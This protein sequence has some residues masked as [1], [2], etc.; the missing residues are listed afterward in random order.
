MGNLEVYN[1]KELANDSER[2]KREYYRNEVYKLGINFDLLS[3]E[4]QK[5]I[6]DFFI[7]LKEDELEKTEKSEKQLITLIKKGDKKT[8]DKMFEKLSDCEFLSLENENG[9][10]QIYLLYEINKNISC[11]FEKLMMV[12]GNFDILEQFSIVRN[13][14]FKTLRDILNEKVEKIQCFGMIEE[15]IISNLIWSWENIYFFSNRTKIERKIYYSMFEVI[16]TELKERVAKQ[17]LEKKELLITSNYDEI[18]L[19]FLLLKEL[20]IGKFGD[21]EISINCNQNIEQLKEAFKKLFGEAISSIKFK[22]L[23]T[24]NLRKDNNFSKRIEE[25]KTLISKLNKLDGGGAIPE[26]SEFLELLYIFIYKSETKVE[27]NSVT[28]KERK[29]YTLIR[30]ILEGKD[31]DEKIIRALN[32]YIRDVIFF[33]K[34]KDD[35]IL[36]IK[37]LKNLLRELFEEINKGMNK[38][39]IQKNLYIVM[40]IF[41]DKLCQFK[42]S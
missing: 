18:I 25:I 8:F 19:N 39:L 29:I 24:E 40:K 14:Y 13:N 11:Q 7:E 16:L 5:N 28:E 37:N 23:R 6:I 9:N 31:K 22:D 17:N 41:V 10:Q 4:C 30:Y 2:K 34:N 20:M 15:M 3:L 12:N 1:L 26:T 33:I 36:Y 35:E 38:E 27:I 32:N 21:K 42:V